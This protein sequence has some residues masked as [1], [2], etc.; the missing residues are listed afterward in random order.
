MFCGIDSPSPTRSSMREAIREGIFYGRSDHNINHSRVNHSGTSHSGADDTIK[1]RYSDRFC[2]TRVCHHEFH[3]ASGS[4]KYA[5][6]FICGSAA[7][8]E[9]A[10][11]SGGNFDPGRG[12]EFG[13]PTH[14]LR[15]DE[16]SARCLRKSQQQ[17]AA[18]PACHQ[19][20]RRWLLRWELATIPLPWQPQWQRL[21]D[22]RHHSQP[23]K[24][25]AGALRFPNMG[26]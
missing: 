14:A 22:R 13:G 21:L 7:R 23:H 19:P 17:Q 20:S 16:G 6:T 9:A 24:V 4:A 10:V 3:G 1:R 11:S 26:I 2:R 18:P 5:S 25:R 15:A 12:A 8:R